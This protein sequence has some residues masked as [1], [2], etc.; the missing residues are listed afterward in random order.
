MWV[1][2]YMNSVAGPG[3]VSGFY[4]LFPRIVLMKTHSVISLQ[5]YVCASGA[6]TKFSCIVMMHGKLPKKSVLE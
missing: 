5:L 3:D 6:E 1:M 2:I 4:T